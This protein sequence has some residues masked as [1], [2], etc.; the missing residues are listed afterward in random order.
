MAKAKPAEQKVPWPASEVESWSL[1]KIKPY[2]RNPRQHPQAQIDLLASLMGRYG[3]DQPIVV[4]EH[5]VILKGHG[6]RLA[7]IKAGFTDFPVVV[8]KGLSEDDKRGLRIA[9][10]KIAL[11]S[12]WDEAILRLEIDDLKLRGFDIDF[13]GFD[14]KELMLLNPGGFLA[15]IIGEDISESS[16]VIPGQRGVALKFNMMP[17]DRDKVIAFLAAERDTRKLRTTAE[18]LIALANERGP[19]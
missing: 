19:A 16:A 12:G 1:D 9:D 7:A 4:D 11:L 15:D 13:L 8:H 6:R 14:E 17:G 5:G 2:D 3:V 18:A 10:N